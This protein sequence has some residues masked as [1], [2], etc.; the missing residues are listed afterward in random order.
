M[1][2]I[3]CKIA[4]NQLDTN[5]I[6]ETNEIIAFDDINPQAPIH[7]LIIPKVHIETINDIDDHE[8]ELIGHMILAGKQIAKD[9]GISDEGYRL[10]FN[11]NMF[12]GQDVF[13]IHLHLLAG[14]QMTWPPG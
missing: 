13:H 5:I 7:K 9:L 10:V 14:R 3:F 2:C 12:G 4:L 1:D 11:C 8:T 6:Y